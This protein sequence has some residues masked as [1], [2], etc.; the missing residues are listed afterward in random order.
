MNVDTADTPI[1]A[2]MYV[3]T[4]SGVIDGLAPIGHESDENLYRVPVHIENGQ[5]TVYV[6]DHHKRMFDADSLPD[7]MKHKLAMI[8][9]T[10]NPDMVEDRELVILELLT[11]PPPVKGMK[12]IGW[13]SST[14]MYIVVM[15]YDELKSLRG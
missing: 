11:P 8:T 12:S 6:G 10:D 4:P 7:F 15:T 5:H 14:S 3:M 9:V 1:E 13:R 2:Y